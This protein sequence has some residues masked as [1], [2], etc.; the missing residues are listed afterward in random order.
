VDRTDS[1]MDYTQDVVQAGADKEL[2]G[3][4]AAV[5]HRLGCGIFRH[6]NLGPRELRSPRRYVMPSLNIEEEPADKLSTMWP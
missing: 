6:G 5:E 3:K 1:A 4:Q 2:G